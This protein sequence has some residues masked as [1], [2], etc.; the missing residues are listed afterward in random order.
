MV[1]ELSFNKIKIEEQSLNVYSTVSLVLGLLQ[2]LL[3]LF[4]F[5]SGVEK[6]FVNFDIPHINSLYWFVAFTFYQLGEILYI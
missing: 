4:S 6:E 3:H 2:W 1:Q 5:V